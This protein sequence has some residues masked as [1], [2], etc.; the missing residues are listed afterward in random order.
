LWRWG[1]LL[2]RGHRC[3]EPGR[4][5]GRLM[6]RWGESQRGSGRLDIQRNVW[7]GLQRSLRRQARRLLPRHRDRRRRPCGCWR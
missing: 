3:R 6:R 2:L 4:R 7:C 5:L 1:W